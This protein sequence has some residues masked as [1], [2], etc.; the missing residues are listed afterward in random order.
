MPRDRRAPGDRPVVACAAIGQRARS[1]PGKAERRGLVEQLQI[2]RCAGD[3]DIRD[4][5]HVLI[6]QDEA[7]RAVRVLHVVYWVD[8][9]EAA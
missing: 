6:H 8:A 3:L 2:P 9:E 1:G 4:R 7:E 5:G